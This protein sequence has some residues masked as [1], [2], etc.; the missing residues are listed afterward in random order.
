MTHTPRTPRPIIPRRSL[1]AGGAAALTLATTAAPLWSQEGGE[2]GEGGEGSALNGMDA[3]VAFLTLLGL[4]EAQ[5]RIVAGLYAEGAVAA[6][7]EHL[8]ASH[9]AFYEDLVAGLATIGAAPFG[10]E[11]EAF[12]AAVNAGADREDVVAKGDAVYAAINAARNH[13]SAKDRMVAAEALLKVA[14]GDIE[15]GVEGGEVTLPQEYRD[16]WGFSEVAGLWLADLAGANAPEAAAAA[17]S[18]LKGMSDVRAQ[19]AG[20]TATAAPGD[21]GAMVA[22]AARVEL[23]AY[24]LK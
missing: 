24:R 13:A 14:A 9:H 11:A 5:H 21:P 18:A 4:F 8:A 3:T 15:A 23:A 1:L 16:A 17:A 10:D 19:F 12:A 2:G 6:A 22:A 20:L 7:Q